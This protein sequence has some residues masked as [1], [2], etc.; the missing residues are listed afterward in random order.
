M[1]RAKAYEAKEIEGL[2]REGY[3]GIGSCSSSL[4]RPFWLTLMDVS[5]IIVIQQMKMVYFL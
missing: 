5:L 4:T 1:Q 3:G 2:M